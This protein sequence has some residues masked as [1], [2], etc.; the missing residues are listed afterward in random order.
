MDGYNLMPFFKGHDVLLQG[1]M[2]FLPG[3]LPE[4]SLYAH[5]R[6]SLALMKLS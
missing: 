6:L 4:S 5:S 3:G 2:Q 1:I